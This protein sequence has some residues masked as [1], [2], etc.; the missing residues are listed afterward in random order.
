MSRHGNGKFQRKSPRKTLY[1][2][3]S[4]HGIDTKLRDPFL[5]KLTHGSLTL[6]LGTHYQSLFWNSQVVYIEYG[7]YR[8][9]FI[10]VMFKMN[11]SV[12]YQIR[13]G[14]S[15]IGVPRP[16][17]RISVHHGWGTQTCS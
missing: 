1:K 12:S 15:H 5:A 3:M 14:A 10:E 2:P 11:Q 6:E 16:C 7:M 13:P 8:N 17:E 9:H 4:R